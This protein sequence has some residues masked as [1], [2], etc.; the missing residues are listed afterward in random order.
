RVAGLLL[1]YVALA[2]HSLRQRGPGCIL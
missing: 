2:E 1:E